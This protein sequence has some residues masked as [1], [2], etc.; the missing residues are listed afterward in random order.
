MLWKKPDPNW[1]EDAKKAYLNIILA[2]RR[3][4]V[5]YSVTPKDLLTAVAERCKPKP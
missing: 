4:C 2:T 1:P 3:I 5:Q